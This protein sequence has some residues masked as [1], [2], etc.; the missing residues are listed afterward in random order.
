MSSRILLEAD[1]AEIFRQELQQAFGTV[2]VA[3]LVMR[4][5]NNAS[6]TITTLP[7]DI[8]QVVRIRTIV[9]AHQVGGSAGVIGNSASWDMYGTFKNVGGTISQVGTTSLVGA[10][11]D[12]ADWGV[13]Y[14][15][16]ENVLYIQ[17]EFNGATNS[18]NLHVVFNTYSYLHIMSGS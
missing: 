9:L 3:R 2:K 13:R 16:F 5:L 17:S 4:D 8:G 11:T 6:V 10:H 14:E 12:D 7:V 18:E 1:N 15:V